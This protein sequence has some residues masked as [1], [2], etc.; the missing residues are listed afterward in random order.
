V[1]AWVL[2]PPQADKKAMN[3]VATIKFFVRD[4]GIKSSEVDGKWVGTL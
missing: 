3:N 2:S 4:I 1:V